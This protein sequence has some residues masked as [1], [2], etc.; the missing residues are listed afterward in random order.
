M[1][2]RR[3]LGSVESTRQPPAPDGTG[4]P[5]RRGPVGAAFGRGIGV[6]VGRAEGGIA[7]ACRR[8]GDET[9]NQGFGA[10][11]DGTPAAFQSLFCLVFMLGLREMES[12]AGV[13][14]TLS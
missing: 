3:G 11:H 10:P 4:E 2:S 8:A 5:G 7:G 9:G 6:V 13:E 14:P 1:Q 12:P